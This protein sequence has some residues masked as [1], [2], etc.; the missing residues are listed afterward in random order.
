VSFDPNL[1]TEDP[2]AGG[3]DGGTSVATQD[4]GTQT[5]SSAGRTYSE[6]ELRST[7]DSQMANARR[8]WDFETNRRLERERQ[9]WE[10]QYRP[11]ASPSAKPD[12]W[13]GFDPEVQQRLRAAIDAELEAR[14]APLNERLS[15]FQQQ[16]EDIAFANDEARI[17]AK[18]PDYQKN[19]AAILEFAV[20]NGIP[21]LDMAYRSWKYDELSKI[22]VKKIERDAVSNHLKRKSAQ[23][24]STPAVEGRGGGT[25]SSKQTFKSR[26]E[27]DDAAVEL[28]R[29]MN[30]Q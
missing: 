14:T 2:N 28:L 6:A 7:L 4:P 5:D 9:N 12:P 13:A 8:S 16:Q 26:E 24:V 15:A 18:Y 11:Q 17:G 22:D 1:A 10:R 23:A 25:P 27:M 20:A 3:Q 21:N 19:R 29:E 30:A